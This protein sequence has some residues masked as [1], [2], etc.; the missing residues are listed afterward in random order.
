MSEEYLDIV[1]ENNN[2]TGESRPR[3]LV[4][5]TGFNYI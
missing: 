1:D 4:H 5:S 3:S 2:L